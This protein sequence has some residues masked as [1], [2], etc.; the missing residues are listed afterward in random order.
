MRSRINRHLH[1]DF[2][3]WTNSSWSRP[4]PRRT[5]RRVTDH[6]T[7]YPPSEFTWRDY[8]VFLLH[9]AA[10]IEHSLMVQYLYA[11]YS[12]GGPQVLAARL[13]V[14]RRWQEIIL[15]VAKEEM[16]HLITVQNVL[17]VLGADPSFD[18]QDYPWDSEFYPFTFHLRPLSL[19]SLAT[20]VCAESPVTWK[21]REA[22]EIKARARIAATSPVNSVGRLYARLIGILSDQ[23]LVP[24]SA[25]Q[26]SARVR[27]ASWDE[28]GRGYTAGIAGQETGNV[29][30]VKAAELIIWQCDSRDSA[31]AALSEV[32]E[33][34]E[35]FDHIK[36]DASAGAGPPVAGEISHF[37]RFLGI[38]REMARLGRRADNLVRNLADN[39]RTSPLLDI[40][41]PSWG[42]G[43]APAFA[44]TRGKPTGQV[45]TN[46]LALCWGHLF[47]LRYRMLLVDLAHAL[48]HSSAAA[49]DDSAKRGYLVNRMFG[50][51]YNLRA[52]AGRIVQQPLQASSNQN[53]LAGPPFEMPYSLQLPAG[54]VDCWRLQHDLYKAAQF[55]MERTRNELRGRDAETM[56]AREYLDYLA[57]AD[58]WALQ[59]IEKWVLSPTPSATGSVPM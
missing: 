16:G 39:P 52:I 44:K 5:R 59:A 8:A 48:Q 10:E 58:Q 51:M 20:Y 27:Q 43:R 18:R 45:I 38:Y 46:H 24:D 4:K 25:F 17:M 3:L 29:T 54:D 33:Q 21:T 6:R 31:V 32:G 11:A 23:S 56:Q 40:A 7:P 14:V 34:G 12:L 53:L 36:A 50:E 13:P 9:V 41:R 30:G 1:H 37:H 47:N 19:S 15:G 55:Q 28:W 2:D 57:E 35:A 26:A 42:R 22:K 49:N